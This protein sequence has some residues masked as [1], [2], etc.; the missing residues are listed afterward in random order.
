MSKEQKVKDDEMMELL[1]KNHCSIEAIMK[2]T[3]ISNYRVKKFLVQNGYEPVLY[4]KYKEGSIGK[5]IPAKRIIAIYKA[6]QLC[7]DTMTVTN[8]FNSAHLADLKIKLGGIRAVEVSFEL[9]S[10]ADWRKKYLEQPK[11]PSKSS[12]K[13]RTTTKKAAAPKKAKS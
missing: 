2:L 1:H 9:I 11:A 6:M 10:V 7:T 5:F 4:K 12:P 8:G 3:G 13:A